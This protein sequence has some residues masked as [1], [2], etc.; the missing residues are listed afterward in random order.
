MVLMTDQEKPRITFNFRE[1]TKRPD[2]TQIRKVLRLLLIVTLVLAGSESLLDA[3]GIIVFSTIE[4]FVDALILIVSSIV[5][6]Y[7]TF[8][9]RHYESHKKRA[10]AMLKIALLLLCIQIAVL[11]AVYFTFRNLGST[12]YF[13]IF[14]GSEIAYQAAFLYITRRY[15]FNARFFSIDLPDAIKVRKDSD[16]NVE[17]VERSDLVSQETRDLIEKRIRGVITEE[18]MSAA[19]SEVNPVNREIILSFTRETISRLR[20]KY[21]W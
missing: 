10:A 21:R 17:S 3:M 2:S 18:E 4:V 16:G 14:I 7:I 5:L 8:P 20:K 9:F 12:D 1:N 11:I 19:L 13:L 15:K 6:A